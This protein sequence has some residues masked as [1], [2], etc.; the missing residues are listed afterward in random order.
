VGKG[1]RADVYLEV[2]KRRGG[3]IF[4]E[5]NIKCLCV[6][7]L[8][9]FTHYIC[10]SSLFFSFWTI[11]KIYILI[12]LQTTIYV[13]WYLTT[14]GCDVGHSQVST[15]TY[16]F[17]NYRYIS[18]PLQYYLKCAG[19]VRKNNRYESKSSFL[20]LVFIRR[21]I[22]IWPRSGDVIEW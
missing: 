15:I 21:D 17:S 13:M 11:F 14:C 16:H 7:F 1:K 20:G 22:E 9:H 19:P 2:R 5:W 18:L 3:H 4:F 12:K 8:V 6:S 10:E